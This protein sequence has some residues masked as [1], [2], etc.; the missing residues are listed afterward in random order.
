MW[1]GEPLGPDDYVISAD[2]NSQL[3]ALS[4]VHPEL[5]TGPGRPR[6]VEFEY[7]RGGTLAYMGAYDVHRAKLMGTIAPT[8]GIAPF[9]ELVNKVTTTEPYASAGRVLWVVDNGGSQAGRTSIARMGQTWPTA[10]LVHPA[11][12]CVVVEPDRDRLLGH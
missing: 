11:G 7:D 12:A 10:T 1:D 3:Q 2:E 8:T 9:A 5:R 6:R 4:R